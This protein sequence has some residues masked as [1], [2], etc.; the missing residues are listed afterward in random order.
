MPQGAFMT[1]LAGNGIVAAGS[2]PLSHVIPH[3]LGEVFGISF[4]NHIFM[5]L[6]SMILL[7]IF[8]PAAARK[9]GLVPSG[10]RNFLEALMQF[11]REQ[12]ARP[13][14]GAVGEW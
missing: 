4:T 6:V 2:D 10:F 7:M 13:V 9:Q 11:I 8:V 14:L 5:L 12:V 1:G 3:E